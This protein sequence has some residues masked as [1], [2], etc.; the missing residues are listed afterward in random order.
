[1]KA[2]EVIIASVSGIE[3]ESPFYHVN[4]GEREIPS[5]EI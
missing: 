5:K 2:R 3:Y 4:D 1:M